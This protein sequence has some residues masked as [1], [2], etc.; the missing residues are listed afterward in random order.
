M[1]TVF[2]VPGI[3]IE[4]IH[5]CWRQILSLLRL[6][7]SPPGQYFI[8]K[9]LYKKTNRYTIAAGRQVSPPGQ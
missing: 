4:P 5:H 7:I 3:G 2:F 1:L 6:P 8:L 9:E